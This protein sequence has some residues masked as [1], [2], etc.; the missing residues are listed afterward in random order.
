M[1]DPAGF[2]DTKI[3]PIHNFISLLFICLISIIYVSY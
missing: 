3:N 2:D 1:P